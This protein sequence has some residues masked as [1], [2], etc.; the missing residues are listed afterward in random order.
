MFQKN[1]EGIANEIELFE[2]ITRGKHL[3][4]FRI[5]R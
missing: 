2:E 4:V 5:N 3:K 1:S